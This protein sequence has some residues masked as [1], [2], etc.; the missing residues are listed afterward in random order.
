VL[1][2][3]FQSLLPS[4]LDRVAVALCFTKLF[5]QSRTAVLNDY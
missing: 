1:L 5:H 2:S 4:R 3:W